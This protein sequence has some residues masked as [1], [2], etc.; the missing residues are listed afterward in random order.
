MHDDGWDRIDRKEIKQHSTTT[1]LGHTLLLLDQLL[2]L[3]DKIHKRGLGKTGRFLLNKEPVSGFLKTILVY[4]KKIC[5]IKSW[6]KPLCH[7]LTD[8]FHY[9]KTGQPKSTEKVEE[10]GHHH[11][12]R[13]L[14]G[15]LV[16]IFNSRN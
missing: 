11:H 7:L 16:F 15:K 13:L 14:R 10:T 6:K 8:M 9:G 2:I 3:C 4:R 12:Q 1:M 5:R